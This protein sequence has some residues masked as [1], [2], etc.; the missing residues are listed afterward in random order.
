M[1]EIK[2]KDGFAAEV[3]AFRAS[4]NALDSVSVHSISEGDVVLPTIDEY[5]DRLF[6]IWTVIFKFKA[7]TAKDAADLDALAVTLK[8]ADGNA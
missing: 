4:G 8:T 3:N 1:A 6:K 5:Q 7:L 2:L